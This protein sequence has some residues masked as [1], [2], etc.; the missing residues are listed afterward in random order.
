MTK[1][2]RLIMIWI[3]ITMMGGCAVNAS[4]DIGQEFRSSESSFLDSTKAKLLLWRNARFIN[5]G[6]Y[7]AF[8][9]ND[10]RV[11]EFRS[12]LVEVELE[13]GSHTITF[14]IPSNYVELSQTP[15][16]IT[17][18][19]FVCNLKADFDAGNVYS[20]YF[21]E[22][23]RNPNLPRGCR[24]LSGIIDGVHPDAYGQTVYQTDVALIM[25]PSEV[26]EHARQEKATSISEKSH[27]EKIAAV[28]STTGV[29]TNNIGVTNDT[30]PS[31]GTTFKSESHLP[32][33][34][35]PDVSTK[36]TSSQGKHEPVAAPENTKEPEKTKQPANVAPVVDSNSIT[37][38]GYQWKQTQTELNKLPEVLRG[39]YQLYNELFFYPEGYFLRLSWRLNPNSNKQENGSIKSGAWK[40]NS[41]KL[42]TQ[43]YL[44]SRGNRYAYRENV[45]QI[46]SDQLVLISNTVYHIADTSSGSI[47]Q[48][49][50][51]PNGQNIWVATKGDGPR[52]FHEYLNGEF[53]QYIGEETRRRLSIEHA[54]EKAISPTKWKGGNAIQPW[55][56]R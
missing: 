49:E 38:G 26:I 25:K 17:D 27:I 41:D 28:T 53:S 12:G 19:Q 39:G 1:I 23:L 20:L 52:L 6:V 34:A 11:A 46:N 18:S 51:Y 3:A 48:A 31:T 36:P 44:W 54:K 43:E 29:S 50:K 15:S 37:H 10:Q 30:D 2:T 14:V 16:E 35:T 32:A 8:F 9:I 33:S 7:S 24:R 47:G 42:R 21:D 40:V 56:N 5:G 55:E 4:K 13:P 22:S 45:Y